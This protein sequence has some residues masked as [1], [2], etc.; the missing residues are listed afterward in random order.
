M[1]RLA[2]ALG[3][4]LLLGGCEAFDRPSDRP[5]TALEFPLPDRPVADV[6][7]NQFSNEDA[8]DEYLKAVCGED[9]EALQRIQEL[10]AANTEDSSFLQSPS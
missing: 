3:S 10:L 5:E 7:S 9:V 2:L 1:Q 6:V 8:R 4:L